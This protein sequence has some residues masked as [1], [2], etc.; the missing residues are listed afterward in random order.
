[1]CDVFYWHVTYTKVWI[2]FKKIRKIFNVT[3]NGKNYKENVC[4]ER[5]CA[6]WLGNNLKALQYTTAMKCLAKTFLFI[7]GKTMIPWNDPQGGQSGKS[8]NAYSQQLCVWEIILQIYLPGKNYIFWDTTCIDR[9][10]KATSIFNNREP[11]L[12]NSIS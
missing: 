12:C 7:A 2:H 8:P 10:F 1:M 11:S 3:P 9:I 5:V 6:S 4:R